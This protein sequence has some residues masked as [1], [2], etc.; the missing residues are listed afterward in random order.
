MEEAVIVSDEG[1]IYQLLV[2]LLSNAA[3]SLENGGLIIINVIDR[4]NFVNVHI[5]DAEVGISEKT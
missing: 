3:N 2:N 5:S 1:K 4:Q